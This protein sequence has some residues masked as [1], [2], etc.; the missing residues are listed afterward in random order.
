ME[1]IVLDTNIL[2]VSVSQKSKLHIVFKSLIDG[3]YVLCATTEILNEYAEIIEKHMGSQASEAVLETLLALPNIELVHTYFRFH[4]LSDED[5]NKFVDCAVAANAKYL[6][7]EDRDFRILQEIN[8]PK[9]DVLRLEV[10]K[11][12]LQ[13]K[14]L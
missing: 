1:R 10:F 8:F 13:L 14:T 4:L 2:L 12:K 11:Q 7:S 9:I 5:D 3:D 6:V